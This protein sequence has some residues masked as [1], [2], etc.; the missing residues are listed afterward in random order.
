MDQLNQVRDVVARH[1]N[2]GATETSVPGLTLHVETDPEV[3]TYV[4]YEPVLA[5]ILGGVK[6]TVLGGY[7]FEISAGDYIVVSVDLPASGEVLEPPYLAVTLA[8]DLNVLAELLTGL[9]A[10]VSGAFAGLDFNR[11]GPELLDP[12]L[13]LV[14]LLDQPEDIPILGAS[15]KREIFW[16]LLH[17]PSAPMVRQI[18]LA[19]SRLSQVNRA[20]NWLRTNYAEP[21]QIDKL[22][23]L[24]GMSSPSFYRHFKSVTAM[25]PLQY[26]KQI[27]LQTARARMLAHPGDVA[28]VGLSVGYESP[29]QFSREYARHF[30]VPP[31]RDVARIRK[32]RELTRAATPR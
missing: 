8:L 16:R 31:A 2:E 23:H 28:G 21:V 25:S 32:T 18:A 7:V 17:G 3:V 24:A 12:M 20:I 1:G 9:D 26:Q 19:D 10:R 29:T 4:V 27:R 30:G 6:R 11:A 14:R 13:R 15:I 5:L 22:A